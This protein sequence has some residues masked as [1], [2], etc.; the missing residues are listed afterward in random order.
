MSQISQNIRVKFRNVFGCICLEN[1]VCVLVNFLYYQKKT[2]S[3]L[4][5]LSCSLITSVEFC[6]SYSIFFYFVCLFVGL[7]VLRIEFLKFVQWIVVLFIRLLLTYLLNIHGASRQWGK[8]RFCKCYFFPFLKIVLLFGQCRGPEKGDVWFYY[9]A[10]RP[11]PPCSPACHS[12]Y[13]I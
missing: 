9:G 1:L 10:R 12:V 13:M 8:S 2:E 5:I 6:S 11:L 7:L 4:S 3:F